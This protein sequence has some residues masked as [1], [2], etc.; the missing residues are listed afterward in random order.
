MELCIFD[1]C[2]IRFYQLFAG[3]GEVLF[4]LSLSLWEREWSVGAMVLGK[5][6]VPGTFLPSSILCKLA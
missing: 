2:I 4:S 5:L 6:P 1:M 3:E